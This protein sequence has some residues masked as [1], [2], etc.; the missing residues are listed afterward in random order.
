[1]LAWMQDSICVTA[2]L[3]LAWGLSSVAWAGPPAPK[4]KIKPQ[5]D[6]VVGRAAVDPAG[7]TIS[8][9]PG[10]PFTILA[11]K[12]LQTTRNVV[13]GQNEFEVEPPTVVAPIGVVPP[14]APTE[15]VEGQLDERQSEAL[16]RLKDRSAKERWEQI[17]QEWLRNKRNKEGQAAPT[18]PAD[19][20]AE[21][22]GDPASTPNPFETNP[23]VPA[24]TEGGPAGPSNVTDV[25]AEPLSP[26]ATLT[27]AVPAGD[28]VTRPGVNPDRVFLQSQQKPKPNEKLP[29]D[30][31]LT[32]MLN[33]DSGQRLPPPVR[34]PNAMPKISDILPNPKQR[35]ANQVRPLPEE[36]EKRYVK[37]DRENSPYV[38]RSFP[39]FTYNFQAANVWANPLYFEDPHLERYG[40]TMHPIAQPFASTFLFALQIGGLPYQMAINHPNEKMYPLG[41]Q[42][43]GDYVPYRMRQVPLSLKAAA[44]ETG[45]ILGTQFATP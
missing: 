42:L 17:H 5:T 44:V 31:E 45:V 2:G 28:G 18:K 20:A 8:R 19:P 32:R 4:T 10:K 33:E 11:R 41:W 26:D 40:H 27:P 43:P 12:P 38:P 16:K 7:I 22:P 13:R 15:L 24:D 3:T 1:M 34:D 14:P 36:D 35:P 25:P 23:Q 29:T 37:L 21:Q 6:A 30:E 9:Q 39:E